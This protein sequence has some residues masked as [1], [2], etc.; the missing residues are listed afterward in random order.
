MSLLVFV[1]WPCRLSF[2]QSN[3]GGG[4][5]GALDNRKTAFRLKQVGLCSQGVTDAVM[6][7]TK[8]LPT[9]E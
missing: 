4:G 3:K 5:K 1:V 2:I 7:A 9:T 8:S 6:T